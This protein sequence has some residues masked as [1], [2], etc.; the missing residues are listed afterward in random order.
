MLQRALV[1]REDLLGPNH[2]D[3]TLTL[4]RLADSF[5]ATGNYVRAKPLLLRAVAIAE[6]HAKPD[7][8]PADL[9]SA[10]FSLAGLHR[11]LKEPARAQPMFKRVLALE[12]QFLGPDHV[13]VGATLSGLGLC[14]LDQGKFKKAKPLLQRSLAIGE[15]VYG[16]NHAHTAAAVG[17]LAVLYCAQGDYQRAQPLYERA[18]AIKEQ[19]HDPE[20]LKV[21]LAL[22]NLAMC[23]A[24]LHQDAR[25]KDLFYRALAIYDHP[26]D[27]GHTHP[28]TATVMKGLVVLAERAGHDD[29]AQGIKVQVAIATAESLQQQC[30]S[31]RAFLDAG[32]ALRC[33]QCQSA[34]YC[35]R[36]C[37]K[38]AWW[39]HKPRC[40]AVP[41]V[42]AAAAPASSV[43]K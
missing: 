13:E 17:N 19:V 16:P 12:E 24:K 26:Y 18:L 34:W 7:R 5:V 10:L 29:M 25:A 28:M 3:L 23:C 31:C 15:R 35:N 1:M 20:H 37:Q 11:D 32:R 39:E 8:F 6:Q 38:A 41:V 33:S 4:I 21:G 22:H 36:V 2:P 9:C 43:K 14:L 42:A 40:H 30:G 27:R